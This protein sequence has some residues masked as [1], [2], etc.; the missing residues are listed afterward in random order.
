MSLT[1][2][3]RWLIASAAAAGLGARLFGWQAGVDAALALTVL[4]LAHIEVRRHG[5]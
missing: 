3:A 4:W 2:F 5:R 1:P